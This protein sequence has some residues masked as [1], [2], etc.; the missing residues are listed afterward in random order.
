MVTNLSVIS[1]FCR[2]GI[3]SAHFSDTQKGPVTT[4]RNKRRFRFKLETMASTLAQMRRGD[5]LDLDKEVDLAELD[6]DL[7]HIREKG[8]QNLKSFFLEYISGE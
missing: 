7:L 1:H 3:R 6:E 4:K 5:V 2:S 8:I